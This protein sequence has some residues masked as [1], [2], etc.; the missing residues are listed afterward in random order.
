MCTRGANDEYIMGRQPRRRMNSVMSENSETG[1]TWLSKH[2]CN[3][4][5]STTP[6]VCENAGG[7]PC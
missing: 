4:Q 5:R 6:S 3:G 7:S 1:R 2:I